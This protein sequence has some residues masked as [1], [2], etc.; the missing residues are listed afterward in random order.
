MRNA[1]IPHSLLRQNKKFFC[2]F[3]CIAELYFDFSRLRPPNGG[4]PSGGLAP[5]GGEVLIAYYSRTGTTSQL[6][7]WLA[8]DTGGELLPHRARAGA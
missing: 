6:A 5:T 8:E 7:E 1:L 3:D 2:N 4:D